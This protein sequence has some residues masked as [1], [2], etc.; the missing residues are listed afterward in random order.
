MFTHKWHVL[1]DEYGACVRVFLRE[2]VSMCVWL[3]HCVR[4]SKRGK[5]KASLMVTLGVEWR[6]HYDSIDG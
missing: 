6:T 3:V 1:V 4:A 5:T 2:C